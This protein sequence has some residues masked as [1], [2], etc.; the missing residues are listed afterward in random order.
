MTGYLID[1]NVIS[2][3][4]K[5]KP[6]GGVLA[7]L[8]SLEL[9]QGYFSAVTFGEIQNGIEVAARCRQDRKRKT[10]CVD[11]RVPNTRVFLPKEGQRVGPKPSDG[12]ARL[13]N[14]LT[15]SSVLRAATEYMSRVNPLEMRLMPRM[16]PI[17]QIELLG[18]GRQIRYARNRVTRP[19]KRTHPEPGNDRS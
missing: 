12:N 16:V 4:R 11:E 9:G 19:S 18:Q 3:V 17:A 2:A 10:V 8:E 6:H 1:T 5:K 15:A 14:Q 7:W 13:F